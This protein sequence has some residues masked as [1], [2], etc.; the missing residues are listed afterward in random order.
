MSGGRVLVTGADGFIGARLCG[1]LQNNRTEVQAAVRTTEHI[2]QAVGYTPSDK[3]QYCSSGSIGPETEWGNILDDV[4]VVVH[5]AAR[6]SDTTQQA[7]GM[8]SFRRINV[9]ATENLARQSASAGVRRLIFLSSV[10]VNGEYSSTHGETYRC[11][12]E[13]DQPA[14]KD[15]YSV[16]KWEAEQALERVSV[17]TGM[18][19]VI[20]RPPLVYGP[21]VS[22]NFLKLMKIVRSG[23]WLPLGGISNRRS[24]IYIDNLVDFIQCCIEHPAASGNLFFVSDMHDISTSELL[25]RLSI[26]MHRPPRLFGVP[27]SLVKAAGRISGKQGITDRLLNSLQ[28]D[29]SKASGVLDWTPPVMMEK[30]LEETVNWFSSTF[31]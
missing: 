21:G 4:D 1:I 16:S 11:F 3:I 27:Q 31:T 15:P 30:G 13:Q 29:T 26:L 14:P 10:K 12:S 18:E 8:E 22:G 28:V 24:M 19:M 6:N 17:D 5:L 2:T 25:S 9:N 7:K 23:I 20:I